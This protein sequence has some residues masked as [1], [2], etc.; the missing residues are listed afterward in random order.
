[1]IHTCIK[2]S[3]NIS[4]RHEADILMIN[5]LKQLKNLSIPQKLIRATIIKLFQAKIKLGQGT[6]VVKTQAIENLCVQRSH[7]KTC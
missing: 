7:S 2:K 6:R 3:D 1:M 4:D 5:E